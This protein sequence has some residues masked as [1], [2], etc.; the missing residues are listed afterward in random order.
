MVLGA[1]KE[2]KQKGEPK[3]YGNTTF[4]GRKIPLHRKVYCTAHNISPESIAGLVVRHKCDNPRCINPEHLELGT[5]KDNV[6]D[7]ITR[8]RAKRGVSKGEQNG[9]S[10][11][12]TQQVNYIRETYRRYSREHGIP[13]I[14]ARLG[15]STSAVHD[16]L[17][18]K[19]WRL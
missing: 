16:V 5:V 10:K 1:C 8:G 6:H 3:G 12:T 19:T 17:K 4:S 13:A 7:C 2:H 15:V 18:A 9:Y 14:A 11:L